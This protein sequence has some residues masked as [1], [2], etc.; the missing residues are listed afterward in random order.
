MIKDKV[1]M[2]FNVVHGVEIGLMVIGAVLF[3]IGMVFLVL[4]IRR[5]RKLKQ[6]RNMLAYADENSP[7]V[8]NN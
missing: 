6:V 7:L 1:L 4:L 3:F 2:P 8:V 5:N